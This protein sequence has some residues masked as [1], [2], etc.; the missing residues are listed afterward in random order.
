MGAGPGRGPTIF[1]GQTEACRA[2]KNYK[3]L[4]I[5]TEPPHEKKSVLPLGARQRPVAY[6]EKKNGMILTRKL[7]VPVHLL[8]LRNTVLRDRSFFLCV[9]V[10]GGGGGYNF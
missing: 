9:C 1:L 2:K 5:G 8:L 7:G 10:W 3:G 6:H 4:D